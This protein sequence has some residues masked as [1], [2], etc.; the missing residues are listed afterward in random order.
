MVNRLV[1][2]FIMSVTLCFL[3][4][5][6]FDNSKLILDNYE[7]PQ[8]FHFKPTPRVGGLGIFFSLLAV[9]LIYLFSYRHLK[10]LVFLFTTLPVFATG[11]A[12]DFTHKISPKWR[13]LAAMFSGLLGMFLLCI[14]IEL[15]FS[16]RR[17]T[18]GMV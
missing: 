4:I 5:K 2:T 17:Y 11:L 1:F 6:F 9:M 15:P 13:L 18:Y 14:S 8:K 3:I 10:F 7:G 16:S 12:E